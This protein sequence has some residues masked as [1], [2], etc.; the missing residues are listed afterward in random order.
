MAPVVSVGRKAS[1][2]VHRRWRDCRKRLQGCRADVAAKPVHQARVALRRLEAGLLIAQTLLGD[3]G[4]TK[5]L[6]EVKKTLT[7]LSALRDAQVQ[8]A[9]MEKIA[10]PGED[11]GALQ[12]RWRRRERRLHHAGFRALAAGKLAQRVAKVRTRLDALPVYAVANRRLRVRLEQALRRMKYYSI[13]LQPRTYEEMASLHLA[14]IA[15]RRYRFVAEALQAFIPGVTES[16]LKAMTRYQS[17]M[18]E[19]HDLDLF[20]ARL[21]RSVGKGHIIASR[22]HSARAALQRRRAARVAAYLRVTG[23]LFPAERS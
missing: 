23:K 18:G 14:R 9:R 8:A 4:V 5:S 21:D 3:G 19:I 22:I 1:R 6:A 7:A 12:E 20:L 13:T 15:F 11:W 16:E 2:L 10:G 17:L